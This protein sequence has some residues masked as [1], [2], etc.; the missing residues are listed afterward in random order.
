MI[1]KV[2]EWQPSLLFM[3]SGMIMRY[4]IAAYPGVVVVVVIVSAMI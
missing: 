2:T 1:Y 4:E 3:L